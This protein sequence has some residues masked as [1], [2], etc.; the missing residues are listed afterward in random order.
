VEISVAGDLDETRLHPYTLSLLSAVSIP[1]FE[2]GRSR[3]LLTATS[4]AQRTHRR[5]GGCTREERPELKELGP[6]HIV[7]CQLAREIQGPVRSARRRH[8]ALASAT[9]GTPNPLGT[10]QSLVRVNSG[11]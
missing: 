7:A 4:Q 6:G 11:R 5:R 10:S 3:T 1:G 8:R 2:R 9:E